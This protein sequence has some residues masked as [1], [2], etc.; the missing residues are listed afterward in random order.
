MANRARIESP[1]GLMGSA[2]WP[3]QSPTR[4]VGRGRRVLATVA[5]AVALII[6]DSETTAGAAATGAA[7]SAA[8]FSFE[9]PPLVSSGKAEHHP[10]KIIWADLVTSNFA[11]AKSFYG[12]LFGWTFT[13]IHTG[14]TNYSVALHDGEPMG[15]I[16]ERPVKEGQQRHPTWLTFI[17]V[18]D[19]DKTQRVVVAHG[20][21]VLSPAHTYA[22]RGRQ[23]V[24]ADPQ[25]AVFA[26]LQS[27]TG[28]PEDA[29]PDPGEWIW[30]SLASHDPG[31]EAAFYQAVFGYEVFD[32]P[33]E[34]GLEH[35]LLS[36]QNYARASS[37]E[38]PAEASNLH[39]H[40]INFIRV[41]NTADA[42][43]KAESLG[44]HVLV[45]PHMDRHGGQIAVVAD[46][47]GAPFGLLEWTSSD[48][49]TVADREQVAK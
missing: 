41:N 22:K 35:V 19:L 5:A 48:T 38:L 9:L 30:S 44:G 29:M 49:K 15:G 18:R 42:V 4:S 33:D 7:G 45:P 10:G 27:S 23:A 31:S 25:G 47:A 2:L 40:W 43:A 26:A 3:T 24:F 34:D 37:N 36:S 12:T 32:L 8:V 13:D 14:E 20:G 28:D 46:P 21:K 39:A 16:I 6:A 17:S 1:N 11:G